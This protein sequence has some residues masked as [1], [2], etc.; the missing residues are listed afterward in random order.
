MSSFGPPVFIV[1]CS[2]SGTTLLRLML[3]QHPRLHI[4]PESEFLLSLHENTDHYGDFTDPHQRWFFIRDLQTTEV[5]MGAYAFSIFDLSVHEA[6]TALADRAPTDFAGAAAALFDASAHKH[7][8]QR[9]GDKTPHYVRHIEWL[10]EAFPESQFVHMIRDGRDVARSRV[11]AGFTVSMRRSARHWKEEVQTG[12]RAGRLLP[13]HRYRE[14]FYEDLVRNPKPLLQDLCD[15][16]DLEFTEALFAFDESGDASVPDEHAHL[17]DKLNAPVDPSRA[18]AWKN[19]LSSREIADVE[20][21]AGDLL[22]ELG[23]KLTG[24]HV[25]LWLRGL[26]GL[27]RNTLSYTKSLVQR[28]RQLGIV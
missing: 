2:R 7:G 12:R 24:K 19:S 23:Y 18:Q 26:R 15:W 21:E 8:K 5:S 14:L 3:T 16:L 10:S 6:E 1:G 22:R 27:H 25:P 28:L 17:H 20:A 4:P 13:A 9:W 11:E